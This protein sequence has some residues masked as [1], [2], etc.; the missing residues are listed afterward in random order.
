[1]NSLDT[2]LIVTGDSTP[3]LCDDQALECLSTGNRDQLA[4]LVSPGWVMDAPCAQADPEAWFP[5]VGE[6]ASHEVLAICRSCPVRRDCLA[7]ALLHY[8]YGIWAG[9]TAKD[10]IALHSLLF[11]GVSAS[12]V[13][14][15]A[16]AAPNGTLRGVENPRV[17]A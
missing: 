2:D 6:F 8:E 9:T 7:A 15:F 11:A 17:A 10:R 16:L 14:E 1:M 12:T 5:D 13:V 3:G 4:E